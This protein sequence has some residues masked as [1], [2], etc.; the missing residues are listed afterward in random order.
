M[1]EDQKISDEKQQRHGAVVCGATLDV[2]GGLSSELFGEQGF[3]EPN[4]NDEHRPVSQMSV[5]FQCKPYPC[6]IGDAVAHGEPEQKRSDGHSFDVSGTKGF[7]EYAVIDDEIDD[8]AENADKKRQAFFLP[9]QECAEHDE[10]YAIKDD[11]ESVE[12][13]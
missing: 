10:E 3:A 8:A 6:E 5:L 4:A 2:N 11:I 1:D 9:Q 12:G 13:T 7:V